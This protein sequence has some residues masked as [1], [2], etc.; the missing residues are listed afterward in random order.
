[1]LPKQ[2]I[3]V[4]ELRKSGVVK[5]KENDIYSMWVKPACCNLNLKQLR[6]LAGIIEP[7]PITYMKDCGTERALEEARDII[8]YDGVTED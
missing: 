3:S 2:E 7:S 6:K 5:L 4:G 8:W 1:M